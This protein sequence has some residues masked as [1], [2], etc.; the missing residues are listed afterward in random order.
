M[1]KPRMVETHTGAQDVYDAAAYDQ[2]MRQSRDRGQLY[3]D[4]IIKSGI[5][6]GTILEIGPGPGYLG[7]E[8][9]KKTDGTRL[10]GLDIS[11]DM[12]TVALKNA[13]EYGLETRTNYLTGNAKAM[14]L[15]NDSFDA[16]ISNSSLHE[17]DDP[18]AIFN[19]IHRVLKPGGRFY[20]SDLRRD[21]NFLVKAFMKQV[22]PQPMLPGLLATLNAAYVEAE[23]RKLLA[24]S[25]LQ[26]GEVTK[27]PFSLIVKGQK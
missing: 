5:N 6:R 13:R 26:G 7:L 11:P 16:V 22:T 4:D 20:I 27:N 19:E 10:T 1:A 2:M 21:I 24:Q 12:V 3:T 15:A 25:K 18:V 14:E 17:W 23:V 8:W 9:L